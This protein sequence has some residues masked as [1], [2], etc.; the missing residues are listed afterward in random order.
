MGPYVSHDLIYVRVIHTYIH[1]SISLYIFF[2]GYIDLLTVVVFGRGISMKGK[3]GKI[4]LFF[5]CSLVVYDI[6]TMFMY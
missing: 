5:I 6:F 2:K 1:T 3:R 4:F